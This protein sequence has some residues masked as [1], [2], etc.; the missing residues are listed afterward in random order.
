VSAGLI[1]GYLREARVLAGVKFVVALA[2]ASLL[3]W[4]P[5]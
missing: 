1:S 3:I 5:L 4:I 2:T